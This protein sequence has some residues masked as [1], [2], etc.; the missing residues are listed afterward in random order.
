MLV[1]DPQVASPRAKIGGATLLFTRAGAIFR[2]GMP[3]CMA[4]GSVGRQ[5]QGDLPPRDKSK[6]RERFSS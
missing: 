2:S 1:P 6:D 4:T 3:E 5:S